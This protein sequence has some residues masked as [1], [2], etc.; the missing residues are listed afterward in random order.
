MH[1]VLIDV[2][3]ESSLFYSDAISTLKMT[4]QTTRESMLR[5][6]NVLNEFPLVHTSLEEGADMASLV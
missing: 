4:V 5:R 1:D 3:V 2:E 6:A